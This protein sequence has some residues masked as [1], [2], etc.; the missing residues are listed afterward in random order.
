MNLYIYDKDLKLIHILP[1]PKDYKE[2]DFST[3]FPTIEDVYISE[4]K[5]S[6]PIIDSG[7]IREKTKLE[8]IMNGQDELLASGEYIEDGEIKYVATPIGLLKP[9][10]NKDTKEWEEQANI[11]EMQKFFMDKIQEY[12]DEKAK[13]Y[14]FDNVF[15]AASYQ[16][17]KVDKFKS[18]AQTVLDWRD[19]TWATAYAIMENVLV[20]NRKIP[21]LEELMEELPKIKDGD[22]K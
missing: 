1:V 16:N 17:S 13:T 14:G 11:E 6:N 19:Q 12:M 7:K 8:L 3:L 4:E 20:G 22:R 2:E 9:V 21:T 15:N 18:D 5:I 10:W